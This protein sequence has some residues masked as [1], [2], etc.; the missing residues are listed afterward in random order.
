MGRLN[1]YGKGINDFIRK[2]MKGFEERLGGT[3]GI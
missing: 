1:I 2:S 3:S